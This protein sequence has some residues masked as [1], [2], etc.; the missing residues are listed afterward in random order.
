MIAVLSII[1]KE[2]KLL[3]RDPG[4]LI[5]L[6]ILPACF[7][8][9]L[10]LA[11]QGTFLTANKKEQLEIL[12]INNDKGKVGDELIK[13]LE[14]TR[15]FKLIKEIENKKLNINK[16]KDLLQKGKYKIIINIPEDTSDAVDFKKDTKIDV[17]VDPVL[18][19]DFATHI[20]NSIQ[21]FIYISILK[22]IT[23]ITNNIFTEIKEKREEEIEKQILETKNKKE[24][25]EEQLAKFKNTNLDE[26]MKIIIG[27]LYIE[28]IKELN[29][30]IN[31]LNKQLKSNQ[32]KS[33]ADEN[34]GYNK[35][36]RENVGLTINLV[37]YTQ[38]KETEDFPNSVQQNVPGWTI[39]ALFWIVQIIT[40]NIMIERQSGSFKRILISPISSFHYVIG[41]SIPFFIVNIIQAVFMFSIGVFIL[42]LF[43]SPPLVIKNILGLLIITFGI[44]LTA[45][46]L[47]FLLSSICKTVSLAASLTGAILIL[48]TVFGGIMV[49]KFIMPKFMQNISLFIPHG[50][51]FD[52]YQKILVKDYNIVQI[53]PNFFVLLGFSIVF[54][55]ISLFYFSKIIRKQK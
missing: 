49:P 44:S 13:G 53:L 11:L 19:S 20:T 4:G 51:A 38:E 32:S 9:V 16:A 14:K 25:I 50:W 18:S 22:N 43:G 28:N 27:E 35:L 15:Y 5:M 2:I 1:N 40:L 55:I 36:L 42:P 21:N 47:S 29:E 8:F 3:L 52:G 7:I 41:K 6:F 46:S 31:E 45:I 30:K 12:V 26:H 24:E 10:S 39:F 34:I 17:I 33:I 48:M 54:I 37:Y 23:N